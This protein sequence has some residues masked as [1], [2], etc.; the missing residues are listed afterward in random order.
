[1]HEERRVQ[2]ANN[3][4]EICFTSS[5]I[6]GGSFESKASCSVDFKEDG[7][8]AAVPGRFAPEYGL[9]SYKDTILSLSES[10]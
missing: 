2:V 8:T 3:P 10:N 4:S 9:L 7:V 5:L 1:M 6:A